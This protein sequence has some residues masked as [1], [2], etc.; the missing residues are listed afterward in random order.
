[1]VLAPAVHVAF[2]MARP[3]RIDEFLR[4]TKAL[5]L[6]S[7]STTE[8][9]V[10]VEAEG[11]IS[12]RCP[13]CGRLSHARHS[14]YWRVLKDLAAQGQSVTLRLHVSRWR[15]RLT[16]CATQVFTERLAGICVPHA[17]HTCR[18]ADVIHQVGYA[19]GGRVASD[20]SA[21]SGQR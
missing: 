6:L 15:C 11:L 8:T 13:T 10:V 19:L 1:M 9:G 20:C 17:R 14:R 21:V 4:S 7:V 18:F 2:V 12:A 3:W 5:R 16:R